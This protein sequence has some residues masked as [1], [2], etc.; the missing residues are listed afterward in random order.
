MLDFFSEK[1][2]KK[3]ERSFIEFSENPN[4][5]QNEVF[6]MTQKSFLKKS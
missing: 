5:Q 1:N 6:Y 3:L 2:Y 4:K